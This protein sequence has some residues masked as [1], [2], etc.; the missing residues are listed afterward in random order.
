MQQS[1]NATKSRI[2]EYLKSLECHV[3]VISLGERL[4][5]D[6]WECDAWNICIVRE[7][8]AQAF[9]Y[10]TGIGYRK[11]AKPVQPHIAG[12]IYSILLDSTTCDYSFDEWCNESGYD[13]DS[14]RAYRA[15][16]QCQEEYGKFCKLFSS[17]EI[18]VLREILQ[19]Y[20]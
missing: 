2:D 10:F 7:G 8:Q 16:L 11:A 18:A 9:D 13:T 20:Y 4:K 6:K 19:D 5:D 17:D 1:T 3:N 12:L 15:Y 14:R